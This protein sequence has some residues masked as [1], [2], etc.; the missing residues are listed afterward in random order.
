MW[1]MLVGFHFGASLSEM[2][3]KR[4]YLLEFNHV[5]LYF[6]IELYPLCT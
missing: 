4:L 6:T 3:L 5:F 1:E 2:K